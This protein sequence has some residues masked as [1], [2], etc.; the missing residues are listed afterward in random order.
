[1][2]IYPEKLAQSLS[3]S[4]RSLYL[5]SGDELLIVQEACDKILKRAKD[6]GYEERKIF[7]P[8]TDGN[9]D[10]LR[11]EGASLSLFASKRIIDVRLSANKLDKDAS[12]FLRNWCDDPPEDVLLLIRTE[13]LL[14]RQRKSA[15]FK[16]LDGFGGIVLVWPIGERELPRWLRARLQSNGIQVNNEGLSY[17][18]ERVEGNLLSAA[19]LIEKMV[20]SKVQG[21]VSLDQLY[22]MIEDSSRFGA[23]D[24][25]NATM[26][27][28]SERLSHILSVL[29][30]E[31]VSFFAVLGALASQIRRVGGSLQGL[32]EAQKKIIG[33]FASRVGNLEFVL[34]E[35]A[36]LDLQAKGGVRGG[37]E[38]IGL[39]RL[40]LRLSGLSQMK[41]MSQDRQEF[42]L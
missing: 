16:A 30:E 13:R 39:E 5:V 36:L 29:R 33:Q 19:Q 17:L 2:Q 8:G 6:Q 14:P 23:F 20:L 42:L 11:E 32:P 24:L 34:S 15:W 35:I 18:T 4:F 9:W 27:G 12:V 37:S 1:M 3:Q 21:E 31:G 28:Q 41:L 22:E 10:S 40:L 7:E 26:A 38:W 25:I